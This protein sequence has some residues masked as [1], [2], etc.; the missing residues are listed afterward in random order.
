[1]PEDHRGAPR[2]CKVSLTI[3]ED[4]V[5]EARALSINLSKAAEAGI[6]AAVKSA[7]EKAWREENRDAIREYNA[8]IERDGV[9]FPPDW[10]DA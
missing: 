1:M 9:P 6:T 8:W 5:E 2:R 3:S 4:L 10:L 7:R